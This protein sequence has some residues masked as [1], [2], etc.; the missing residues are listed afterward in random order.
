MPVGGRLGARPGSSQPGRGGRRRWQGHSRSQL[1]PEGT[2][3]G[4]GQTA[5]RAVS[6]PSSL[7][8]TLGV[9]V[10]DTGRSLSTARNVHGSQTLTWTVSPAARQLP[11]LNSEPGRAGT[12]RHGLCRIGSPTNDSRRCTS[13]RVGGSQAAACP[14]GCD[15]SLTA[16][17]AQQP[18]GP[19]IHT[20]M[21]M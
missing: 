15:W 8:R 14:H 3:S 2:V 6:V 11:R 18:T 9:H 21:R 10:P 16:P 12:R 17:S 5:V 4:A 20:F 1:R 7:Y 19:L 13:L